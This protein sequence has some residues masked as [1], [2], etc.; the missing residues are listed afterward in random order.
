M[1]LENQ[2]VIRKVEYKVDVNSTGLNGV[3]TVAMVHKLVCHVEASASCIDS[4][5]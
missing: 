1:L 2:S 5:G 3:M 4:A